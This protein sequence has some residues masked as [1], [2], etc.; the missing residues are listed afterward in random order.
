MESIDADNLYLCNKCNLLLGRHRFPKKILRKI[1][2]GISDENQQNAKK[3]TN[4]KI[5]DSSS[6]SNNITTTTATATAT[7]DHDDHDNDVSNNKVLLLVCHQCRKQDGAIRMKQIKPNTIITDSNKSNSGLTRRP[8]NWG[9]C[10]Y[11]DKL[12]S[13]NCYNDIVYLNVFNNA[14]DISESMAAIYAIFHHSSYININVGEEEGKDE[15]QDSK[16]GDKEKNG[17]KNKVND[18][19]KVL[20][21][22]IGDGCTPRTAVLLSFLTKGLWD[23]ISI[24]P[25]LSNEWNHT[26]DDDDDDS[27]IE[28][29][30]SNSSGQKQNEK[31]K[32]VVRGLY[33]YKG[34]LKEFVMD[35]NRPPYINKRAT[36][37]NNNNNNNPPNNDKNNN[38]SKDKDDKNENE[39]E[40]N[41]Y[42][43][44]ILLC[45]HSHARFIEEST[46]DNI[47]S[48]YTNLSSSSS[49]PT[50]SSTT[51]SLAST[52]YCNDINNTP[53]TP[54]P[55][56]SSSSS[57]SSFSL[58]PTTI[59]SL[60]CCPQYRHVRDIGI[61][62]NIKYD[63]DCVFSACR[64][65]EVWNL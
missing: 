32:Q 11:L 28:I 2:K 16:K 57:S 10:N 55:S 26:R 61:Q 4:T 41:Y 60:P 7:D 22:C 34:T 46:V 3:K 18:K 40:N 36:T 64:S 1:I 54:D 15:E 51:S 50:S 31:Q 6:S 39:N 38:D 63:D 37:G 35:S 23:C 14:K 19:D 52:L 21:L 30:S 12:F 59:V 47:R 56:S 49:T 44:L 48:L 42:Q 24:D 29:D 45:V 27:E 33:G 13:M 9:Y 17:I 62:P 8:N 58:I 53:M 65:V 5:N 25:A 43:H 20:C